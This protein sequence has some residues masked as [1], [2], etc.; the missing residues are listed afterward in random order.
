MHGLN[1]EGQIQVIGDL[2]PFR[3][4]WIRRWIWEI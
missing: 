2:I 4:R 1:D 3:L